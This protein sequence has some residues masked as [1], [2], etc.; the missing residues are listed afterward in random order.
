MSS[1]NFR[2]LMENLNLNRIQ[3]PFFAFKILNINPICKTRLELR[4]PHIYNFSFFNKFTKTLTFLFRHGGRRDQ[5]V[6]AGSEGVHPCAR[7][8]GRA[9]ALPGKQAH[10]S[11]PGF[12][13]RRKVQDLHGLFNTF[14]IS[15]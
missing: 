9:P 10:S 8:E 1:K 12:L 13:H 15:F 4:I 3:F 2:N 14:S 7:E 5:Q 6:A 11:P